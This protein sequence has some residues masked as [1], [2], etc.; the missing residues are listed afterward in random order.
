MPEHWYRTQLQNGKFEQVCWVDKRLKAG[1]VVSL[2]G[3]SRKWTVVEQDRTPGG[4]GRVRFNV[5]WIY[6]DTPK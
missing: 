2:I 1:A 5:S 4:P 6:D 3:N